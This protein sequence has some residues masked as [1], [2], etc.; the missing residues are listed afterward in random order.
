MK[1]VQY[2]CDCCYKV[3]DDKA[4][5]RTYYIDCLDKIIDICT[6][7]IADRL[8]HSFS[9][10]EDKPSLSLSSEEIFGDFHG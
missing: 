6:E 4:E 8:N 9:V 5:I 7:C 1:Q 10:C 3:T 2:Y